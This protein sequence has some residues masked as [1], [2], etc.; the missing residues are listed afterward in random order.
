MKKKIVTICTAALCVAMFGIGAYANKNAID[1]SDKIQS[2][3]LQIDEISQLQSALDNSPVLRSVYNSH[4]REDYFTGDENTLSSESYNEESIN[5]RDAV[6]LYNV[7]LSDTT[8]SL[9]S[10]LDKENEQWLIV[11]NIKGNTAYIFMRKGADVETVEK[12]I[13]DL[14]ISEK[15]KNEILESA[16]E[17]AGKWYVDRVEQTKSSDDTTAEIANIS[18]TINQKSIS[19]AEIKYIYIDNTDTIGTWIQKDNKEYIIPYGTQLSTNELN[20]PNKFE[21]ST[22]VNDIVK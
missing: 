7:S 1:L 9:K 6:K 10:Q 2:D 12:N 13:S 16:K 11:K 17:K 3:E 18:T 15:W 14:N 20:G 4:Y 22:V 5:A 19:D 21:L 8:T